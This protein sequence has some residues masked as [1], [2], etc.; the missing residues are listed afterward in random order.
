MNYI[1]KTPKP[2]GKMESKEEK[3]STSA[4]AAAAADAKAGGD[5]SSKTWKCEGK[6]VSSKITPV[7]QLIFI[8]FF[9]RKSYL[10]FD[11][12]RH[13]KNLMIYASFYFRLSWKPT[14]SVGKP[15]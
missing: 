14:T 4:A 2:Q 13:A 9:K 11:N 7:R 12:I 15:P 3:P 1:L 10:L 6:L 5:S 8:S